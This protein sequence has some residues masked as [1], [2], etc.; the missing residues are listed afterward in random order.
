MTLTR[1]VMWPQV[2]DMLF[3]K[4]LQLLILLEG[5]SMASSNV[6]QEARINTQQTPGQATVSGTDILGSQATMRNSDGSSFAGESGV[7]V[8]PIRSMVAAVPAPFSRLPSDS[9]GNPVGLYYPVLGRFQ[10]VASGLVSGEQGHQ[11][12]GEHHPAGLQ[13]EQ[14]SVP[15]AIGQQNAEDPARNGS[16]TITRKA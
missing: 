8:V 2:S 7:R 9:S 10:H 16:V 6:N 15:D 13:T 11:V 1:M 3:F 12:S 4:F 5:S 14:P